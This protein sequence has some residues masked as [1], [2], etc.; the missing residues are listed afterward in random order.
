MRIAN[1]LLPVVLSG[2]LSASALAQDAP[3]QPGAAQ[4]PGG[5]AA[6]V[7]LDVSPLINALDK[8]GKVTSEEW[9]A[10]GLPDQ[11]FSMVAKDG[12]VT[13]ESFTTALANAPANIVQGLDPAGDGKLT[14]EKFQAFIKTMQ[15]N[16]GPG[17]GGG[18]GGGP[19]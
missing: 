14:L 15:A 7:K 9:Q 13:V 19:Q 2:I 11:G 18:Q 4:Q 8:D 6:S 16:G 5:G 3:G 12:Y 1:I 17:G 10:A